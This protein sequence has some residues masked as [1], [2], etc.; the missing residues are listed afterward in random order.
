MISVFN[1]EDKSCIRL[2]HK[3]RQKFFLLEFVDFEASRGN[4]LKDRNRRVVRLSMLRIEE[5][6]V[7]RY[8]SGVKWGKS[9]AERRASKPMLHQ[10]GLL[11][12]MHVPLVVPTY[13]SPRGDDVSPAALKTIFPA[14][15]KQPRN[16]R[17][18]VQ[19]S[20]KS[21]L[22]CPYFRRTSFFVS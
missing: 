21:Q 4:N 5:K 15:R 11:L 22:G 2:F 18:A 6:A 20:R 13:L 16:H 12:P 9:A 19:V 10:A 17:C 14:T 8:G 7:R 3:S 1:A